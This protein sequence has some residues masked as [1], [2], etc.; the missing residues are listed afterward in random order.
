MLRT[1]SFVFFTVH[2]P[3]RI[4]LSPF[5]SKASRRVSSFFLSVQL[6]QPY[7]ATGHTSAFISRI[8]FI[9]NLNPV[10]VA[11]RLVVVVVVVLVV[12]VGLMPGNINPG[13]V[14]LTVVVRAVVVVTANVVRELLEPADRNISTVNGFCQFCDKL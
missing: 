1:H 12:V 7:V 8:G 13:V 5:V 11:G 6:S 4:L 2:E 9:P 3:R 10:P 14:L